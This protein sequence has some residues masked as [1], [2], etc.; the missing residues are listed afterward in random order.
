MCS[1]DLLLLNVTG[2]WAPEDPEALRGI[3]ARQL[4]SP[5]RWYDAMRALIASGV[6]TVVEVGPGNV[7]AGLMRKILPRE[8]SVRVLPMDGLRAF[9]ALQRALA[10]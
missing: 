1:S 10:G 7:L 3:M 8:S 5:V 4:C 6:D 2:D 9:E